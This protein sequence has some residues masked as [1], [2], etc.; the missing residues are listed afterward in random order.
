ME[1]VVAVIVALCGA[2][3]RGLGEGRN[4]RLP[5]NIMLS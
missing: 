3:G 2:A 4:L 5:Y 1:I